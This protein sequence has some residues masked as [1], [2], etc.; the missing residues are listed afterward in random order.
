MTPRLWRAGRHVLRE[1]RFGTWPVSR[2]E[3]AELGRL[4]RAWPDGRHGMTEAELAAH[5]DRA[6]GLLAAGLPLLVAV[7]RR[8]RVPSPPRATDCPPA[9]PQEPP[10]DSFPAASWGH[11]KGA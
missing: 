3:L 10:G 1:D 11:L 5:A 7:P 8:P 9:S 2:R 6:A 4:P